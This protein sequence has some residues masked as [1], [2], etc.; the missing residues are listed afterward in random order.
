M[1]SAVTFPLY[2]SCE[3]QRER[4]RGIESFFCPSAA[5]EVPSCHIKTLEVC[6]RRRRREELNNSGWWRPKTKKALELALPLHFSLPWVVECHRISCRWMHAAPVVDLGKHL[7]QQQQHE[8]NMGF[9]CNNSGD[10]KPF[11]LSY[12]RRRR[13]WSKQQLGVTHKSWRPILLLSQPNSFPPPP[14]SSGEKLEINTCC[15]RKWQTKYARISF[16]QQACQKTEAGDDFYFETP[17]SRA[18]GTRKFG[19]E[20]SLS[21]PPILRGAFF[22]FR[23]QIRYHPLSRFIVLVHH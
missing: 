9:K 11:V 20:M 4:R 14:C 2:T 8:F 15:C 1:Q 17:T 16:M 21:P 19:V 12:W 6:T 23:R 13:V 5:A 22:Q 7:Q 3:L 18:K 10:G